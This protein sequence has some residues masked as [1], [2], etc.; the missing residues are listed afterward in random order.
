MSSSWGWWLCRGRDGGKFLPEMRL[1]LIFNKGRPDTIGIYFERAC[2][3]LGIVADHWWL[4]D[5]DRIAST[6]DLYLRIDHGDDYL[7]RLPIHLRPSAF[8]VIDTHLLHSWRKI[9]HAA[10]WYNF[11]FC[12]QREAAHQLAGAQW[13]PLGCDLQLHGSKEMKAQTQDIAFVGTDG[14]IPRKFYLQ[15]LRER[16][17]NS[18]IG[19]ADYQQMG[20]IYGRARIGF[21]YSI[22]NDVN[23]RIFEVA[24]AQTLLVTN[25]LVGNA[26]QTLGFVDGQHLILYRTPQELMERIDYFLAPPD[27][28]QA[29]VQAGNALVRERHTYVHRLRQL[30]MHVSQQLGVP[31]ALTT[32]EPLSCAS[33]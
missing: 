16:Y 33:S 11:V 23:M 3:A 9:R 19:A 29:I 17:P 18:Y 6:Y 21:N 20:L 32:K 26:L 25:A 12:A 27:E 4:Q 13:L 8:Y 30:L 7:T 24:A 2:H 22:R 31:M 1:A 14:A 5:I 10:H 28:R 15:A